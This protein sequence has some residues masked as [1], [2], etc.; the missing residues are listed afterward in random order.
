M[1]QLVGNGDVGNMGVRSARS[2]ERLRR[3][4]GRRRTT[5]L[6][7]VRY[8]LGVAVPVL[9]TLFERALYGYLHEATLFI[10]LGGVFVT[11][12]AAGIG[13]A[14]LAAALSAPLADYFLLGQGSAFLWGEA[15]VPLSL[16]EL[17]AA[18]MIY[19]THRLKKLEQ[20]A[21]RINVA[22]GE[23]LSAASHELR[24]PLAALRLQI[25]GLA[26]ELSRNGNLNVREL[27]E[28]TF[29]FRRILDRL[30]SLIDVLLDM[31]R[32]QAGR[33]NLELRQVDLAELARQVVSRFAQEGATPCQLLIEADSPVIGTWDRERL[34]QV[35]TN[36]ISNAC[37]YGDAKP[38]K[39]KVRGNG[40]QAHLIVQDQGIG[41][42]DGQ[43]D[44]IFE[45]FERAVEGR[46]IRG[47]GLG[48]WITREI[49]EAHGG[50]IRVDSE[51]GRGSTF[52]VELRLAARA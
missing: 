19:L 38:V 25:E 30:V 33:L 46:N 4:F 9:V 3:V 40:A 10:F 29:G 11:A 44:R 13:P 43:V 47:M 20:D 41:I 8:G 2:F 22:Q 50:R 1:D 36:L 28:R 27:R 15:L 17:V 14:L 7:V 24:S 45:R 51:P 35:V 49:V 32:I 5:G 16:F 26:R 34:D 39:V 52:T 48:L 42:P 31:T 18:A 23:F 21:R 37:K 12:R 6:A